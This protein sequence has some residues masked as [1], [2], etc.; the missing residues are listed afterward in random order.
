MH[1]IRHK[2]PREHIYPSFTAAF[3]DQLDVTCIIRLT[4]ERLLTPVATLRDVV[5][6]SRDYDSSGAWHQRWVA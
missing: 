6:N 5:G 3:G 1:V 2:A 4:E